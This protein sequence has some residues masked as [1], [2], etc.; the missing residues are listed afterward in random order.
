MMKIPMHIMYYF[1]KTS[2]KLNILMKCQCFFPFAFKF[3]KI[4]TKFKKVS[5]HAV[6]FKDIICIVG[7]RVSQYDIMDVGKY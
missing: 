3:A 1:V 2:S 4:F 6:S 5:P 7:D